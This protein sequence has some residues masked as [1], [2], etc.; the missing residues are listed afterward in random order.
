MKQVNAT[1]YCSVLIIL[2]GCMACKPEADNIAISSDGVNISFSSNGKGKPAIIFVP[3][4]T[5][6]KSIWDGQVDHFSKKYQAVA[7]DLAGTGA[8]GDDR[9]DWTMKAFGHD[10]VSVINKL[11]LDKVVLVGFSMGTAVVIEAANLIPDKVIGVVLVD[12]LKDPDA[13]YPPEMLV[14]MD[15]LM[16]DLVTNMTNEKLVD[17]GFYK[18]NPD[19]SFRR[20][21]SMYEGVS[22]TGWEESLQGYFKWVNEDITGALRQLKVPVT[23]IYSDLE[24]TNIEASK[25]YIPGFQAKIMTGVGHLLFWDKPEEFNRLLEESIQEFQQHP[26]LK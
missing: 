6:P 24:P 16:M 23:A 13:R 17:L 9:S 1:F 19:S 11:K 4:W 7:I 10:V 5:N 22:Q 14:V 15:S 2:T 26:S 20:I 12:D 21:E 25:K 3:G 8:S 18:H